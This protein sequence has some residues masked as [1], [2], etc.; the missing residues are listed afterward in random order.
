MRRQSP[1]SLFQ[2]CVVAS[3]HRSWLLS[4]YWF[5]SVQKW[6]HWLDQESFSLRGKQRK[7]NFHD[8]P[9]LFWVK[10][11]Y[12]FLAFFFAALPCLLSN[13]FCFFGIREWEKAEI[14]G[15]G[16]LHILSPWGLPL[17]PGRPSTGAN[18]GTS[19]PALFLWVT[20]RTLPSYFYML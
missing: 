9:W 17:H 6:Y 12:S 14:L 4:A 11:G 2:K 19:Q 18:P 7:N 5:L 1:F 15:S 16:D 10:V 3:D 8:S 20:G 13:I